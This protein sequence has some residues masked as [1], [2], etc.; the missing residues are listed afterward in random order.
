M[1]GVGIL[2]F[3]PFLNITETTKLSTLKPPT[4]SWHYYAPLFE[5]KEP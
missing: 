1:L 2:G 3:N 4:S 5:T